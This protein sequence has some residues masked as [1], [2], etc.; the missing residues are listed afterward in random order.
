MKGK[1]LMVVAHPDDEVIFGYRQLK[2]PELFVLCVTNG[3]NEVRRKEF[4]SVMDKFGLEGMMWQYPDVW[5]G[6]F[7]EEEV[8]HR[9]KELLGRD[10]DNI[11]TH[12]AM[13]DYGH[14]QHTA[15]HWIIRQIKPKNMYVFDNHYMAAPLQFDE[16]R[17]KMDILKTMYK[18][19]YD[20]GTYD[21]HETR[22][23][24]NPSNQMMRYIVSEN[25]IKV[26]V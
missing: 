20:L 22:E 1:N 15:L 25:L 6:S 2:N 19:Q 23:Y 21:W 3:Q 11:I 8:T 18:S 17:D 24:Y 7:P 12:N 10:Y 14:S 16:L 9:I 26:Q 13:G 4:N 5:D